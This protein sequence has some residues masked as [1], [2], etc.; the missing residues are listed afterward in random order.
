M[1]GVRGSSPL[2]STRH[3][4][5]A[6]R[7]RGAVCQQ[8]VSRSRSVTARTLSVVAGRVTLVFSEPG[9]HHHRQ[10]LAQAR[11]V[12]PGGATD[13]LQQRSWITQGWSVRSVVEV[14]AD[15]CSSGNRPRVQ[16][17][18]RPPGQATGRAH[19]PRAG[20]ST[21]LLARSGK[22]CLSA[23]RRRLGRS[24]LRRDGLR[25]SRPPERHAPT[26]CGSAPNRPDRPAPCC[27]CLPAARPRRR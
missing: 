1:Q 4:A 24:R 20:G 9:S 3:N 25:P 16:G 2:S 23:C 18:G 22:A 7:P 26:V 13:W 5:S 11:A 8:I 27:R 6:G 15:E 14:A 10:P 17:K 19:H 21:A 12:D